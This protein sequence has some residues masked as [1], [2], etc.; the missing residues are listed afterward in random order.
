M[1]EFAVVLLI[2]VGVVGPVACGVGRYH[3]CRAHGFSV[4][5][6]LR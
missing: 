3:E 6:C 1:R 5:Y 2:L 4:F